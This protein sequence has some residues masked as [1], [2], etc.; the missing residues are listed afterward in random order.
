MAPPPQQQG[1]RR[2]GGVQPKL[3]TVTAGASKP[4]NTGF[5]QPLIR[6]PLEATSA[7]ASANSTNTNGVSKV[8]AVKK[9][10]IKQ[11]PQQQQR[12]VTTSKPSAVAVSKTKTLPTSS[13]AARDSKKRPR[14]PSDDEE[15]EETE[16]FIEESTEDEEAEDSDESMEEVVPVKKNQPASKRPSSS[17]TTSS[18]ILQGVVA[19]VQVRTD[20]G[21]DSNA[22]FENL[23]TSMGAQ[24]RKSLSKDCTHL[25]FKHGPRS[26]YASALGRKLKVVSCVWVSRYGGHLFRIYSISKKLTSHKFQL[27]I[28]RQEVKRKRIPR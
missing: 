22:Y 15:E 12:S 19:H 8:S 16:E 10:A 11:Q 5:K 25:V 21:S 17:S 9:P 28:C 4:F 20:D 23:L 3:A 14:L 7:H 13:N 1:P 2:I 24:T 26:V 6:K 27:Q 18:R